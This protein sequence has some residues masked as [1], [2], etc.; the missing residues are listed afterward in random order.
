[1]TTNANLPTSN[2]LA[3]ARVMVVLGAL[4]GCNLPLPP[5]ATPCE[6]DR[7]SK[8]CEI[9]MYDHVR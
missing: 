8:E 7:A 6:K 1:M 4:A 3:I 2:M 9:W 5:N